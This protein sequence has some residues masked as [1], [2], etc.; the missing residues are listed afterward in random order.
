MTQDAAASLKTAFI[1]N[2][3]QE[4]YTPKKYV[5]AA[6]DC[7]IHAT[8]LLEASGLD[9]PG[10]RQKPTEEPSAAIKRNLLD[11]FDTK[12]IESEWVPAYQQHRQ[13]RRRTYL[14]LPS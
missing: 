13:I 9:P 1:Y 5:E 10:N 12:D 3:K 11:Q 8:S 4:G 14:P 7:F 2:P 6:E